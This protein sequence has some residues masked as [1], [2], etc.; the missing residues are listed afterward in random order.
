MAP[1]EIEYGRPITIG[2]EE[3]YAHNDCVEAST[4]E[5]SEKQ[6]FMYWVDYGASHALQVTAEVECNPEDDG[7]VVRYKFT[8]LRYL[9][10]NR[11]L[12]KGTLSLPG[13]S[14]THKI[15]KHP[16]EK[17]LIAGFRVKHVKPEA[18]STNSQQ[19][20]ANSENKVAL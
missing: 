9:R 10:M 17:K 15:A 20:K 11:D 5:P 13:G 19:L 12:A 4:V 7:G 16:I 3:F 6:K 14:Q 1:M 2:D 8:Q 18:A